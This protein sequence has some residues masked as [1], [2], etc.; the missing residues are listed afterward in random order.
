MPDIHEYLNEFL[1]NPP[2]LPSDYEKL[3]NNLN[4][5]VKNA[6]MTSDE[7]NKYLEITNKFKKKHV[8]Y[9]DLM[10]LEE[11]YNKYI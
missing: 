1:K 5:K 10:E 4:D 6:Q 9:Q 8:T 7:K 2:S 11:I 3:A